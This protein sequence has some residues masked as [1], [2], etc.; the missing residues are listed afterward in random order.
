MQK[1]CTEQNYYK[2]FIALC[3]RALFSR[4]SNKNTSCFFSSVAQNSP[5]H[6]Q[7]TSANR[8]TGK[9]SQLKY[10]HT[11]NHSPKNMSLQFIYSCQNVGIL[12]NI[13]P[14]NKHGSCVTSQLCSAWTS[15]E[16]WRVE[17]RGH[18]YVCMHWAIEKGYHWG[19]GRAVGCM[20][21]GANGA[22]LRA[23]PG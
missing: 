12:L 3:T 21:R 8:T 20:R 6:A 1:K 9:H 5:Q 2:S 16:A 23:L 11:Y 22:L 4:W 10:H 13:P 7:Y 19:M 17:D 15:A 14:S 18:S